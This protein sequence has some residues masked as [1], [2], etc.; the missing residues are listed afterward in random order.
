MYKLI[1]V[2]D[3]ED[4]R[5]SVV[6][7]IDW[8]QYGFE[9]VDKAEN[10]KEALD[11]IERWLPDVVVTDI[12]MPFMDGMQLSEWIRDKYPTTKIIILTGF[13]EFEYAQKAVKMH[14]DEY[15]LK[16]FSAEELIHALIKIKL[17]LDEEMAQ[18]E[19]VQALQEHYRQSLPVLREVFL[20]S[21]INRRLRGS[22]IE[23]KSLNYNVNLQGRSFLL[24]VLSIDNPEWQEDSANNQ[25][26]AQ[27]RNQAA[28]Q[29][30]KYSK[31]NELK[32]F[33]VLNIS[34]E[35]FNRVNQGLVFLHHDYIV[36]LTVDGD[37][38]R[39]SVM[40]RTLAILDEIRQNIEKYLKFTVTLGVGTVTEDI[41]N[42]SYSH[43]DAIF[44]LDYRLI[45][46]NN[47][48]ICIDDV[49]KRFVE[50]LR[51]DELKEHALIRCIKVGTL[52]ELRE[53][54]EDLFHGIADTQV[55]IKDYQIYLL[56][57]L[58]AILKA[59]KAADIDLDATLG[60]DFNPFAEVNQFTNLQ[61]AK[62][63]ITGLCSKLMNNIVSDRQSAY[64]SLVD[65]AKEYT[66][67]NF[68]ESDISITKVCQYLHISTGYFSGI[69]KKETK[70][71]FVGY[72]MQIRMEAAKELL[73][74]TDLRTLDIAERVGYSEPNYFS[75]SFRKHVGVSPKEYR[76]S[77][78]DG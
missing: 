32:W 62:Q 33:A 40:K 43:K 68:Q 3:E 63:W 10:G 12:K 21:L 46:G 9:V 50:K 78:R 48:V 34:E 44:A 57:I 8:A 4:V 35:I 20:A 7:E 26:Q 70:M 49:E 5:E 28:S 41:T 75:F 1:L 76:S 72:L 18:K 39:E 45:L 71:T 36:L 54:I 24:S 56:E 42:I 25:Q 16:P 17:L 23:E 27:A 64:K 11:M 38:D 52:Q 51:F 65:K 66:R 37:A 58:T 14:I 29:S 74:T 22:E 6:Q 53:I 69:F 19:N 15:V 60:S 59:A 47:R 30:L 2:E 73:R 67:L 61:E 13:D 31:D 55:S 77:S